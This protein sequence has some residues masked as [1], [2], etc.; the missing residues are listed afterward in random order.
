MVKVGCEVERI[1]DPKLDGSTFAVALGPVLGTIVRKQP[2]ISELVSKAM[3]TSNLATESHLYT[4]I[5]TLGI[6]GTLK[7]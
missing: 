2:R 3:K 5:A 6:T 4:P 1:Y 7:N